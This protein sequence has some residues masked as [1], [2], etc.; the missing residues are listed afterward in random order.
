MPDNIELSSSQFQSKADYVFHAL[1]D[2][3]LQGVY[4]PG[5]LLS[6]REISVQM[7][8]SRTPVKEAINKLAYDG[9]VEL[10]PNR[11]AI[12]ARISTTKVLELLELREALERSTAF[13]AAQRRT[14]KDLIDMDHINSIHHGIDPNELQDLAYWDKMF[15]MAI[16]RATYNSELYDTV[17]RVFEQ[18]TRIR[19]PIGRDRTESSYEQH[20]QILRSIHEGN[21]E[22][23]EK[24]MAAHNRDILASVKDYQFKNIHLFK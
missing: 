14:E 1:Q 17:N 12:V 23:A 18:L 10:L 24:Q 11:S 6:I 3:I 22:E 15:H 2:R 4:P 5:T 16:A 21:A 20:E 19:L 8:V 9:Y 7:D 13:Y